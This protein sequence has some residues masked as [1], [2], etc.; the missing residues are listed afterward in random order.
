MVLSMSD[1][2]DGWIDAL[3]VEA[4]WCCSERILDPA[5]RSQSLGKAAAVGQRRNGCGG[6]RAPGA[7]LP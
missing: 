2:T 4:E 7:D 1:E 6:E 3:Q 5:A